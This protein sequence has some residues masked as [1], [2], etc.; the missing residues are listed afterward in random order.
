MLLP[1]KFKKPHLH[2]QSEE[3]SNK[4]EPTAELAH[5]NIVSLKLKLLQSTYLYTVGRIDL[6]DNVPSLNMVIHSDY[7]STT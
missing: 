4:L 6:T 1:D 2:F 5:M 7:N 3:V